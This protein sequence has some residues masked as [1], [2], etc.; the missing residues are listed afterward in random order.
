M[1]DVTSRKPS[2][3]PPAEPGVATGVATELL[4]AGSELAQLL[5]RMVRSRSD[6]SLHQF[7][8]LRTIAARAPAA[9][10]ASDLTRVL[11][12]SSAHATAV[13]QQLQAQELIERS[14]SEADRRRRVIRLTTGGDEALSAAL[15][16]LDHV[17]RGLEGALGATAGSAA[18][19][20]ELRAI[21]LALRQAL[22]I[23]DWEN[24]VGP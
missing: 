4:M 5:E 13:L 11:G 24:C 15:P 14:A 10:Y 12:M 8:V 20:G 1:T 18:V 9:T 22:A 6:L 21:R 23:E 17:E 19:Q 7:N 2:H 16:A 3:E